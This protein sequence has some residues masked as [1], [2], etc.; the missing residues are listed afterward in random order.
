MNVKEINDV[1]NNLNNKFQ[2]A[3]VVKIDLHIHTPA[4]KCFEKAGNTEDFCYKS[5]VKEAVENDIKIIAITDHNT[6]D[7]FNKVKHLL[8]DQNDIEFQK[9][10]KNICILCGIE[11]DCL[12]KHLLAI[13]DV[14]FKEELQQKF[15]IEIGLNENCDVIDT[16]GPSKLVE[17]IEKY[18]GIAILAHVDAKNGFFEEFSKE[19][20]FSG[21]TIAKLLREKALCGIQYCNDLAKIKI[22]EL[23]KQKDYLGND[24][25][26]AFLKFSDAHGIVV[27]GKYTGR[28]GHKIGEEYSL[29]KLSESSFY[30]LKLALKDP[31]SRIIS[32]IENIE[33]ERPYII[34]MAL[35]CELFSKNF[36]NYT[37]IRFHKQMNCLIGGRGTGKSTILKILNYI[38]NG[39][40][41]KNKDKLYW[42]HSAILYVKWNKEV[43]A[44]GG[45]YFEEVDE[46]T[47]EI[48]R[49]LKRKTY[50]LEGEK[51]RY[52]GKNSD[53]LFFILGYMQGQLSNMQENPNA[54]LE[55][56]EYFGIMRNGK[57]IEKNT[58]TIENLNKRLSLKL[59][60]YERN[61]HKKKLI[62]F[63]K[64][65][66]YI[67]KYCHFK[68]IIAN[69]V[70]NKFLIYKDIVDEINKVLNKYV[71][72][73]IKKGFS[74]K[75]RSLLLEIFCKKIQE[76]YNYEKMIKIKKILKHVMEYSSARDKFIF[77]ALLIQERYDEL[78]KQYN[79]QNIDDIKE[80]L[81]VIN[82]NMTTDMLL[83]DTDLNVKMS[84]NINSYIDNDVEEKF[85][86]SD[87]ISMG[88]NAVAIL[89]MI[90]KSSEQFGDSKTLLMDQPEDDLDNSYIFTR[91]V[92]EFR[93]TK[94]ARQIII[95]T[96]NPNIPVSADAENIIVLKYDGNN[97]NISANGSIDSREVNRNVLEILEGSQKALEI[98]LNKYDYKL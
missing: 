38:L 14:T 48:S 84:Y 72:L 85:K 51:F 52:I 91:L 81:T 50:K 62:T 24:T 28:S 94:N 41:N 43:Y 35:D 7:G 9:L 77:F 56:I 57:D 90:L 80:Y 59:E 53:V 65:E 15:M 46:Y 2:G 30:G 37:L 70:D 19:S 86:G 25:N 39:D 22:E 31:D 12:S 61:T 60:E 68:E 49:N 83:I 71:K 82:D 11:I 47:N 73:E 23:I 21:R 67:N 92:P 63:L 93:K 20:I 5:L 16:Y 87:E 97:S 40:I 18:G 8:N 64:D 55:I 58:K 36:S 66:D 29:I 95:S 1:Y 74:Y 33:D 54:I 26:I 6:F 44:I 27:N 79:L 96:H 76:N 42:F 88:Q 4:S 34:G 13:F 98:R 32:R 45:S 3:K 75:D 17:I 89:H 10:Q 78:I 69:A